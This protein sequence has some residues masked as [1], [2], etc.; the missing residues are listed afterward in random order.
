MERI[1]SYLEEI[2]RYLNTLDEKR[3]HL[4]RILCSRGQFLVTYQRAVMMASTSLSFTRGEQKT[5]VGHNL[6]RLS[7]QCPVGVTPKP[8]VQ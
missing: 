4:W 1:T 8:V 5:M 3:L 7:H 6:N 2:V